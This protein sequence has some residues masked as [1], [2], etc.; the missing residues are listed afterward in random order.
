MTKNDSKEPIKA[1]SGTSVICG[2][3]W[4]IFL[5]M[6]ICDYS[7]KYPSFLEPGNLLIWTIPN[8]LL[9]LGALILSVL[10]S[11][12]GK[13][14]CSKI[15]CI[16]FFVLLV[17]SFT[18][19]SLEKL[20]VP[21]FCS[22]TSNPN[23]FA[24]YDDEVEEFLLLNPPFA[25]FPQEIPVDAENIQY[26]YFYCNSSTETVFIAISWE[27]DRKSILSDSTADTSEDL[28][29]RHVDG[30]TKTA[31]YYDENNHRITYVLTNHESYLPAC[32]EDAYT[33]V[34]E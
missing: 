31:V 32:S 22:A 4:L 24:S 33:I 19:S 3:L 11:L 6:Y 28:I 15:S 18:R 10:F 25:G 30:A 5:I 27:I 16:L 9:P 26:R 29:E 13:H 23:H 1:I 34:L 17:F 21:A 14:R 2:F 12:N 7:Y 8:L 20:Y